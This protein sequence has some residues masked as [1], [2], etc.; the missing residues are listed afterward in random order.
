MTTRTHTEIAGVNPAFAAAVSAYVAFAC[1]HTAGACSD[2][3]DRAGAA[4]TAAIIAVLP[5]NPPNATHTAR[6]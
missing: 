1:D 4:I 2:C 6:N 3:M 5:T